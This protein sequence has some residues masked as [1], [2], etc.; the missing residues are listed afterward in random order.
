MAEVVRVI[1]L[2]E[3]A[4]KLNGMADAVAGNRRLMGEI[5]LFIRTE[6]LTRTAD[7][8]DVDGDPFEPYSAPYAKWREKEGWPTADVD[9]FFT[10][11][12]LSALT[13]DETPE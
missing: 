5:G 11:S 2:R 9:L 3:L 1:G 8:K 10:G 6:I 7:G 12:M 4:I 13:Y